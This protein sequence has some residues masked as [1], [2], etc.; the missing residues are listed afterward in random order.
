MGGLGDYYIRNPARESYPM[1][2]EIPFFSHFKSD[3]DLEFIV[4]AG[5]WLRCPLG[6]DI[7]KEKEKEST[8]FVVVKGKLSVL[9]GERPISIIHKG[10]LFGE[11]G[12]LLG[13]PRLANVMAMEE[14]MLFEGNAVVFRKFPPHIIVPFLMYVVSLTA[15]RL[16][17]ADRRLAAL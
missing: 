17:A 1:L 8:F 6:A 10:E 5:N 2:R 14:S 13:E 16:K 15:K 9:K 3:D 12:A 4:K 11:L 7:I